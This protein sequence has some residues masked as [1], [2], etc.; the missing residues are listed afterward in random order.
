[1]ENVFKTIFQPKNAGQP[2]IA[3]VAEIC[4]YSTKRNKNSLINK[5][6]ILKDNYVLIVSVLLPLQISLLTKLQTA[7]TVQ[8]ISNAPRIAAS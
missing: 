1:M 8:L 2:Y 7:T 6:K 5:V 4:F 3:D